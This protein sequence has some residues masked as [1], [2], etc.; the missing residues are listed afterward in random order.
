[1]SLAV[2]A[3]ALAQIVCL[4]MSFSSS[5]FGTGVLWG[6]VATAVMSVFMIVATVIG[7]SPLPEPIP[8][9]LAKMV[10]G[11]DAALP[12]VVGTAIV[13]HLG[14]GGVWGGMLARTVRPVTVA[15]GLG[16]GVGLWLLMQVVV[17]PLLGWGLFGTAVSIK[18]AVA[19]LVL[20]L[21]YGV[22]LGLG[23]DRTTQLEGA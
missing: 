22:T 20:H 8:A 12:V 14:Y 1:M 16:L 9:A 11:A 21:I 18:V 19:T 2:R 23:M 4:V 17:L 7:V 5:R 15:W 10:V 6:V 13:S 3:N